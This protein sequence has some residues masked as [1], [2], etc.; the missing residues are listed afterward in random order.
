MEKVSVDVSNRF[1][2]QTMFLYGT[3]KED[4]SPNFGLFC[5]FSYCWDSELRVMA[6]IGGEKLTKDR[7]HAGNVFSANLVSEA[8]LPMADYLGNNEGR[9]TGKMDAPIEIERG[10]VLPVP[11]LKDSP[12]VFELE[13]AQILPMDDGE[14]LICAIRNVLAA[15]ALADESVSPEQ[16]MEFAAPVVCAGIERYF[17]LVPGAKGKWGDWRNGFER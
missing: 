16:R 11:V 13:V 2:P 17:T 1:C 10:A 3:Y 7:I 5:W 8:M 6:C 15:K 12:W 4:G 9:A 14:V